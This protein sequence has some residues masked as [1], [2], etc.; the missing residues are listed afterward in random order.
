MIKELHR[1]LKF[2]T[3]DSSKNWFAVGEY[4]RLPNEVSGRQTTLPENV[5]K[6]MSALL[7]GYVPRAGHALEDIVDFHVGFERIHPFQDGNGR[8][9]RLV[10]FKE[11]L[12]NDVVPFIITDGMKAFYYRGLAEWDNEKG[13]LIDTCLAAQDSFRAF[14]DYFRIG[15]A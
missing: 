6:D 3:T 9:G 12:A 15:Q 4:K 2:G 11:C 7:E 1:I 8:V 13:F 14:L 5:G 10:M